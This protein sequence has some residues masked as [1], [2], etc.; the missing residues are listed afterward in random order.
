MVSPWHGLGYKGDKPTTCPGYTCNL[1]ETIEIARARLHWSKNAHALESFCG[2]PVSA[3]M[4]LGMEIL[5]GAS[6]ELSNWQMTPSSKG[7]GA[8]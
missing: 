6:N 4:L 7:G 8:E 5:E 1:P 2:G 3:G